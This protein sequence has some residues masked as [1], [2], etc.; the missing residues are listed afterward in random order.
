MSD[1]NPLNPLRDKD[2]DT[3]ADESLTVPSSPR[4]PSY[5][6]SITPH[7]AAAAAAVVCTI[8][9]DNRI[10][11]G[12]LGLHHSELPNDG[13]TDPI[14][15][16]NLSR[17]SRSE[18][19][20]HCYDSDEEES[21]RREIQS[22]TLK[23][24]D[25]PYE[26]FAGMSGVV[27][28]NASD[29]SLM[30]FYGMEPNPKVQWQPDGQSGNWGDSAPVDKP[31]VVSP[32]PSD[33]DLLLSTN[34]LAIKADRET[35]EIYDK[36]EGVVIKTTRM[37]QKGQSGEGREKMSHS[38]SANLDHL[39]Q[40]V[41]PDSSEDTEN[42]SFDP[43]DSEPGPFFL[44]QRS[45][46]C[47]TLEGFGSEIVRLDSHCTHLSYTSHS[48]NNSTKRSSY[49]QHELKPL[50]ALPI[51]QLLPPLNLELE[52]VRDFRHVDSKYTTQ[53]SGV[54][55]PSQRDLV[56]SPTLEQIPHIQGTSLQSLGKEFLNSVRD[57]NSGMDITP[58]KLVKV[59]YAYSAKREDEFDLVLDDVFVVLIIASDCWALGST[60][61]DA[62]KYIS[63]REQFGG[64]S[65]IS[66]SGGG[67]QGKYAYTFD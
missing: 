32:T 5:E 16:M 61:G 33:D 41:K 4:L 28:L 47:S 18:G 10:R 15:G 26:G 44:H 40:V 62:I 67:V 30:Q 66:P 45:G 49:F 17:R 21:R 20:L 2:N 3:F 64:H 9:E 48:S 65:K 60:Y 25:S 23:G 29:L 13:T 34:S 42:L 52:A 38:E 63:S 53:E 22:I 8:R 1:S 43:E 31:L 24:L 51:Q 58:G 14:T 57:I 59:K 6:E 56:C 19:S 39:G 11:A 50:R 12:A 55:V 35:D 37:K 36:L 27:N 7:P 46:S 54:S